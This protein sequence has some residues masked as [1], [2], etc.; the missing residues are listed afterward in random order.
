[1]GCKREEYQPLG[2]DSYVISHKLNMRIIVYCL[3][4]IQL[5][6]LLLWISTLFERKSHV[7]QNIFSNLDNIHINKIKAVLPE[8]SFVN[9]NENFAFETPSECTNLDCEKFDCYPEP[10]VSESLCVNRGCCWKPKSDKYVPSCYYKTS[11]MGYSIVNTTYTKRGLQSFLKRN[12]PSPYSDDVQLLKM[13][14]CYLSNDTV[15]IK[16]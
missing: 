8:P 9:Y 10:E 11:Y 16:V 6:V 2:P 1:M 7:N 13:N 15:H 14:I 5:L 12:F 4:I 3:L